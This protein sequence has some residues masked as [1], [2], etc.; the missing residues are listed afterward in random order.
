MTA[1]YRSW[2][3]KGRRS[4]ANPPMRRDLLGF[5]AGLALAATASDSSAQP[6]GIE[7]ISYLTS[8][9][10]SVEAVRWF[11]NKAAELAAGAFVVDVEHK[12]GLSRPLQV[13]SQSSPL[14]HF[15][16]IQV[17]D[18]NPLFV[19]SSLPMVA[20]S[21]DEAQ[22]LLDIARPY[23]DVALARFDLVFLAADPW[24]PPALWSSKPLQS[25]HDIKGATYDVMNMAYNARW[26]LVFDRLGARYS[27]F[28]AEIMLTWSYGTA[29]FEPIYQ[30][31]TEIFLATQLGFLTV[32]RTFMSALPPAH[33]EA[34]VEAA[35]L[36]EAEWWQGMRDMVVRDQREIAALGVTVTSKPPQ[37]LVS[38]LRTV[39]EPDIER[40]ANS[41]G[42]DGRALLASYREAI[43]R[44]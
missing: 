10:P 24:R 4:M 35:R 32:G 12:S 29:R 11:A 9:A 7:L 16:S 31:F 36:A 22:M 30:F 39:A 40:W 26:N 6:A 27:P 21:L 34:L 44:T 18:A 13:L 20:T 37:E 25:P 23:Y 1:A 2:E 17:R 28:A 19:L 5:G 43:G 3:R 14:S 8:P 42:S 38:A 15:L 33:R 41:V